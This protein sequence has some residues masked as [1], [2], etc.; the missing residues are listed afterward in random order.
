MRQ[1]VRL[2]FVSLLVSA[3]LPCG[4]KSK[5]LSPLPAKIMTAKAVVF[6]DQSG[7]AAVGDNALR[8]LEKWGRFRVVHDEKEA[9]LIILLTRE[10]YG[11]V[12]TSSGRPAKV[13]A[14]GQIEE[15]PIQVYARGPTSRDAQLTVIDPETKEILWHYSRQWGGLLTGFNS[16]GRRLVDELRKVIEAQ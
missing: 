6:V 11:D 7:V 8:E 3:T 12:V 4:T 16:A 9:D 1:S 5:N 13:D 2:L 14:N 15:A 10:P